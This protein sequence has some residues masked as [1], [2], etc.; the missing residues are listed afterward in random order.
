[1][2]FP[3]ISE[4]VTNN[5]ASSPVNSRGN[6]AETMKNPITSN[7]LRMGTLTALHPGG[8]ISRVPEKHWGPLPHRAEK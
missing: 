7:S 6:G 1:M 5:R 2:V 3:A 8:E 4:N